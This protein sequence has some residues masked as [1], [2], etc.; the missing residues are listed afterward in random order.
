MII[1]S[2]YSLTCYA[3]CSPK[4]SLPNAKPETD[5]DLLGSL[6][7]VNGG[8]RTVVDA[9]MGSE[10]KVGA[11]SPVAVYRARNEKQVCC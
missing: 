3:W 4:G 10:S 1:F 5:D 6:L 8:R 2:R 7:E 11:L 9:R